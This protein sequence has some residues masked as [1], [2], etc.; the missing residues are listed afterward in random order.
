MSAYP[1]YRNTEHRAIETPISL[2][3]IVKMNREKEEHM[4]KE[5]EK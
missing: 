5:L 4:A 3:V 2:N 1:S